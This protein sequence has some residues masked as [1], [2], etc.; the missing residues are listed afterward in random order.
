VEAFREVGPEMPER[1]SKP[2]TVP[3]SEQRLELFVWCDPNYFLSRLVT[4]DENWLYHYYP[5][6]KQQ[7]MEFLHGGSPSP[8]KILMQKSAGKLLTLMF[9]D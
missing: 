8:K 7:S 6:T 4:T 2:S 1:G 5:E 9:W 3:S